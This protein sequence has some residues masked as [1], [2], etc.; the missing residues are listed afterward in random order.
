M[1]TWILENLCERLHK[2]FFSRRRSYQQTHVR[3]RASSR[4][5]IS[6][7]TTDS[8]KHLDISCTR[9][10][11]PKSTKYKEYM[12]VLPEG[13]LASILILIPIPEGSSLSVVC[14]YWNRVLR[15][16]VHGTMTHEL[17]IRNAAT[18][19]TIRAIIA[20]FRSLASLD[21]SYCRDCHQVVH[22]SSISR[23]CG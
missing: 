4:P 7:T 16:I 2:L 3:P 9:S 17:Q 13:P 1:C 20:R 22:S 11:R 18:V 15:D 19:A 12:E 14:H 23:Q 10:T 21:L 6:V 5:F 8:M